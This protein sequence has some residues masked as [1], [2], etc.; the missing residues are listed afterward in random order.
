MGLTVLLKLERVVGM[1]VL[2]V[3][4]WNFR[5]GF[6]GGSAGKRSTC[7]EGDVSLI[8]GSGRSLGEGNGNPLQDSCLGNPMD[9]GT[10]LATVHGV[11]RESGLSD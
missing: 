11:A 3:R 2:L 7:Q 8:P 1:L 6:P 10:W 5:M 4:G 9:R